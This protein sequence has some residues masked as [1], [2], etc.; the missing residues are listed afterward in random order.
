MFGQLKAP[1][2]TKYIPHTQWLW[3]RRFTGDNIAELSDSQIAP[4]MH[5]S[6]KCHVVAEH[7]QTKTDDV[8]F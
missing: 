7:D 1:E 3:S 2:G 4:Y 8:V 6:V 5:S